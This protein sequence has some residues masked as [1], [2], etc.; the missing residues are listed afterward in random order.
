[1]VGC[2][3]GGGVGGQAAGKVSGVHGRLGDLGGIDDKYDVA[4]SSSCG[5]LDH[6]VVDNAQV[7]RR[8][9]LCLSFA[10]ALTRAL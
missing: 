10:F 4:I 7:D 1:M 5:A 9:C 3:G 8:F 2:C 6:V